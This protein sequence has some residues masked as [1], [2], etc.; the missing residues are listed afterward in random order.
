M[1]RPTT[2]QDE[3]HAAEQYHLHRWL[4]AHCTARGGVL[5]RVWA[6]H[7]LQ[8]QVVGD[9]NNWHM[10]ASP[11]RQTHSDPTIWEAFVPHAGENNFYK[12]AITGADGVVRI[13]S[14]PFAFA[15]EV[16]PQDASRIY[17]HTF[18]WQDQAWLGRRSASHQQPVS[19]YEVHLGSWRR[20]DGQWL[21]YTQLAAELPAYAANLGFTHV[22]F[23][24][25]AEHLLDES[26]GY[27]THGYFSP[28]QRY[29]EPVG[30]KQLIDAC[31]QQGLGVI[32]DWSPSHFPKD[33]IGLAHFDGTK[34]F[35]A[36]DDSPWNS[37]FFDLTKPE[38]VSFL[39]SSA[40]Y[41]LQEFHID[42]LRVDAV[43]HLLNDGP[44]QT[45]QHNSH[46]PRPGAR[47][48]LESLTRACHKL[49]PDC[50]VIA[51][52]SST[53]PDVTTARAPARSLGF[54][55][56]WDMGWMHDSLKFFAAAPKDRAKLYQR[57]TFG[58]TYHFHERYVRAYSHDE[59]VHGKSPMLYKMW[60]NTD[61]EKFANLHLLMVLQWTL[62]GKKL[63]FMGNEFASDREW[64][65]DEALP[66]HLL[67]YQPHQRTAQLVQQLN[68]LYQRYEALHD[69]SDGWGN[70]HWIAC[71]HA[72]QGL[73]CFSRQS[74]NSYVVVALNLLNTSLSTSVPVAYNTTM[75]CV[76]ET[77]P[78][79]QC[80]IGQAQ[81]RRA[82]NQATMNLQLPPLTCQV[83]TP[84][85]A[86]KYL[87]STKLLEPLEGAT[88]C[89]RP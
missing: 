7:A 33:N 66:W 64:Q 65:L 85:H 26:W 57:L 52:D 38:V 41:W 80:G 51:E 1:L 23:M 84:L 70:F 22:E 20:Q 69:E 53:F 39:I 45:R 43:N 35:E 63:T 87:A 59:V 17:G 78:T 50:M 25:L 55:Y 56:K 81:P 86:A 24:P 4:G 5:F 77:G 83:W 54:D 68:E 32:L 62:P 3:F 27:Q 29:G 73:L 8:V 28:T 13:K 58:M 67:Q 30:L 89:D 74:A 88:D 6:P 44:D 61:N 60:G 14:D 11:M 9:F 49:V 72:R 76:L 18:A 12:Y 48:F 16:R 36:P 19:I 31:H 15:S 21:G 82:Q 2:W 34:L 10:Q 75:R 37:H 42:G 46:Q 71:D 79:Q 47:R 40:I